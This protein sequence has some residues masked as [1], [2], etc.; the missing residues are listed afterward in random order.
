MET[1]GLTVPS[2]APRGPAEERMGRYTAD[3]GCQTDPATAVSVGDAAL[4]EAGL[5]SVASVG[6][7]TSR[8]GGPPGDERESQGL[9]SAAVTQT[10][11][12]LSGQEANPAS[13]GVHAASGE[14][15]AAEGGE[16]E[17]EARAAASGRIGAAAS[18]MREVG[19][20]FKAFSTWA[21]V[22]DAPL[23]VRCAVPPQDTV[24]Y[25]AAQGRACDPES[26]MPRGG[27]YVGRRPVGAMLGE[28]TWA[29]SHN[30]PEQVLKAAFPLPFA[31]SLA[32]DYRELLRENVAL[33][34][35]VGAL[36]A[37]LA[38]SAAWL[39]D[40]AE[41]RYGRL[42]QRAALALWRAAAGRDR[43]ASLALAAALEAEKGV[44]ATA[45]EPGA[46]RENDA[47]EDEGER[48][49]SGGKAGR[50]PSDDASKVVAV[51]QHLEGLLQVSQ[52][53]IA[54]LEEQLRV[55]S[56]QI[57]SLEARLGQARTDAVLLDEGRRAEAE[58]LRGQLRAAR[59]TQLVWRVAWRWA[60][61]VVCGS[62]QRYVAASQ[63]GQAAA[64]GA[65]ASAG[66]AA[67]AAGSLE[68]GQPLATPPSAVSVH[69]QTEG[70]AI[71]ANASTSTEVPRQSRPA[72]AG[73]KRARSR[74]RLSSG[75]AAGPLAPPPAQASAV[76][77][78]P[79]RPALPPQVLRGVTLAAR[80]AQEASAVSAAAHWLV[81]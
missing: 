11:V 28:D 5:G 79:P 33:E 61:L 27:G 31:G 36:R 71:T 29:Q 3:A 49:T 26:T 72:A 46:P 1:A 12:A 81:L 25:P 62:R 76:A 50:L 21:G 51:R 18:P 57:A 39:M 65:G 9:P 70:R 66:A 59:R 22:D 69:S 74:G 45:L 32:P 73:P 14:P 19:V 75:A 6:V 24:A 78:T 42:V 77:A 44:G 52:Q 35:R 68:A 43:V 23:N 64:D 48:E 34:S 55:A 60:Q 67:Q 38:S 17:A 80:A 4:A 56:Q 37:H 8:V 40:V 53:R 20:R 7:Q 15:A 63:S 41:Q 47:G 58:S 10:A 54:S 16:R 13:V 30:G 2:V